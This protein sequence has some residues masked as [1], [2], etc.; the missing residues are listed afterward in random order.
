MKI[1]TGGFKSTANMVDRYFFDSLYEK[2]LTERKVLEG[3]HKISR[4]RD[5]MQDLLFLS[6]LAPLGYQLTQV[7]H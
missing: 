4:Q 2:Q 6:T 1:N 5:V 7:G 3:K